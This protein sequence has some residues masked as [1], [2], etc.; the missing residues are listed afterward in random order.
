MQKLFQIMG[1][2][3]EA[4]IKLLC[5]AGTLLIVWLVR[6]LTDVMIQR[7]ISDVR[8]AYSRRRAISNITACIAAILIAWIW[9]NDL[10]SLST[11]VGLM[12]AGIAIAMHDTIANITGW[13]FIF[14]RKPFKVGDRIQ[15]GEVSGDVVDIRFVQFSIIEVGNWVDAEQS[16]GRIIHIPNSKVLRDPLANYQTGFDYIWHE[17]PVLI[18]FE[19]NWSKAKA[20]LSDI[21]HDKTVHL[22]KGM[23]QEIRKAAHRYMIIYGKLT[24]IVYTSVRDSGVLL[25][26]R[27][28][29]RPRQRRG[30][31]QE[32]WESILTAFEQHPD[33]CLAYPTTRFFTQETDAKNHP[34]PDRA[35]T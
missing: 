8:R 24:P 30:T 21:V 20:L 27:Y 33:I 1:F 11:F 3:T 22:S 10:E 13:F 6:V 16:T 7:R 29:V 35:S 9:L 25:T 34:V 12:S 19:S 18:T 32:I 2:S 14:F 15:I 28:L 23:E 4:S 26:I 31:E 17:I 5:T